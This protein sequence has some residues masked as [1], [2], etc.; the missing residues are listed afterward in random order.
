MSPQHLILSHNFTEKDL[1]GLV[2]VIAATNH[3]TLLDPALLRRFDDVLHY[4]LPDQSQIAELLRTRLLRSALKQVRWTNL[5]QTAAGLNYAEVTR[6]A[7]E[8]LKDAL[9]RQRARVGEA[10]I[11][12]ML[13]ERCSI[14]NR[15]NGKTT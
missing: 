10:D 9:V 1:W 15:L 3:P 5:A 4:D 13:E 14:A 8:V 6:A 11:R 7:N 12:L 2:L